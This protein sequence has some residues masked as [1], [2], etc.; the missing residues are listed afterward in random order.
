MKIEIMSKLDV[1]Q[2]S[3][4]IDED[5]VVISINNIGTEKPMFAANSNIKDVLTLWFD[6]E[7][8]S[9][10]GMNS[11]QA[12]EVASFVRKWEDKTK[13][14]VVHCAA[15]VSRSAGVAAAIGKALNND[16][17]F[18]FNNPKYV[19]NRNCYRKTLNAFMEVKTMETCKGFNPDMTCRGFQ[20][21]E[22]GD[23][24]EELASLCTRG[25]HSC[26]APLNTFGYYPPVDPIGN[27]NRFHKV[28]VADVAPDRGDDTKVC[29]KKIK[30][31]KQ[32]DFDEL[33]EAHIE[34]VT[35]HRGEWEGILGESCTAALGHDR[36]PEV[37]TNRDI[38]SMAISQENKGISLNKGI[39][40]VAKTDGEGGVAINL[41]ASSAASVNRYYA[42]AVNT[43]D[44]SVSIGNGTRSIAANT[45][46]NSA[47]IGG[48]TRSTASS[49]GDSSA[50]INADYHSVATNT[51]DI[52]T[53]A[54]TGSGSVAA[55]TGDDSTTTNT[56]IFSVAT[57]TGSHS[58]VTSKGDFS[59][60]TNTGN[61]SAT[62]NTG[63][64]SIAA[65]TG[66]DSSVAAMGENSIAVAWGAKGKAKATKG[67]YIVLTEWKPKYPQWGLVGAIMVKVDGERFKENTFYALRN[68]RIVEVG[69]EE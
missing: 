41:E 9:E 4:I 17:T 52:S 61:F 45:G 59:A 47:A 30:I 58:T 13:L 66:D 21:E 34:W 55:N 18:V 49:T 3:H 29:S 33:V 7:E 16:D 10:K 39:S 60:A 31:G 15:G 11:A 23:Y 24:E 50:A 53:A 48:N 12:D 37:V 14:I 57:S 62:T 44:G 42:V 69:D 43:G 5:C 32:L 19:P 28:E 63:N 68:G 67:S 36:N 2:K 56:G 65:N 22:G 51:G 64:R 1:M 26:A 54:N 38:C 27:P 40:S 35:K 20:Y 8:N 46:F 6:D 25:F